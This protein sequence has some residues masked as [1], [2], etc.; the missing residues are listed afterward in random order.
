MWTVKDLREILDNED[1]GTSIFIDG[2]PFEGILEHR[3]CEACPGKILSL[4]SNANAV[5]RGL[6][7]TIPKEAMACP[8]GGEHDTLGPCKTFP[9]THAGGATC[10]K[11]G[12]WPVNGFFKRPVSEAT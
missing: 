3:T 12:D 8:K 10:S 5:E 2:K 11:C 1:D 7:A 6:C 9:D 4:T